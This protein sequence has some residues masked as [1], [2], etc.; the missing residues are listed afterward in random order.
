MTTA[1]IVL[2]AMLLLFVLSSLVPGDPATALL[3]PQ[4]TPEYARQFVVQMGLDKPWYVRL[5]IYLRNVFTG[6]LGRDL[7]SGRSVV[8]LVGA[9]LPY[10]FV[11]AFT[12]LGLA[13]VVGVPL[14]AYAGTHRGSALDTILTFVSVAFIA[15]PGFVIAIALLLIF[16][17]SL[18]WLPVMGAGRDGDWRDQLSHPRSADARPEP[19]VGRVHR[20]A[21]ALVHDRSARPGL[22]QDDACLW[23]LAANH[24]V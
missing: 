17:I 8:S 23:R 6:D 22:H 19:H 11:L 15:I 7:L 24:H 1:L 16:S 14:G 3:G 20:A 5:P 10:T 4:A 13:I 12:S 9:V 18:D 21:D 2:G